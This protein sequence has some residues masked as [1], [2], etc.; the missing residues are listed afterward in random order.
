M[1]NNNSKIIIALSLISCF[2]LAKAN[3]YEDRFERSQQMK[4][5]ERHQDERKALRETH[6]AE[7]KEVRELHSKE[8]ELLLNRQKEERDADRRRRTG[9]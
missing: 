4:M 7:L 1:R 3:A 6:K 9:R 2:S 8:L 5:L